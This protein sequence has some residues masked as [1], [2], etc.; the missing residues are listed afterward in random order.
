MSLYRIESPDRVW[1]A[2]IAAEWGAN[3]IRLQH[4]GQD[5]LIP[6]TSEQQQQENP[7]LIGSPLLFPANR[8]HKGQ[9]AFQGVT[10]RL[11]INEPF[12]DSHLHGLLHMQA[13]TMQ[14]I[15]D[16]AIVLTYENH[17]EIYPF[18]FRMTV[19]YRLQNEGLTQRYCVENIG[20]TDM[21]FT[22][23]LH[24]TFV[25]PPVF[26]VPI[27]ACQEKDER[28]IPTGRYVALNEQERMYPLG[29]PSKG[30]VLSGYYKACGHTAHVGEY[31]Y[32]VS[33]NF[34]H[35][36]LFNGRG[37]SGLLCVEPQCG[38]VNG[39]NN[40]DC[41]VLKPGESATFYTHLCRADT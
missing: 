37:E 16:S 11:P 30:L 13:F 35:W 9:F 8:T 6:L 28:H 5:V 1:C 15:T 38:A 23:A 21:P 20:T 22:F 19:E 29:S 3:V 41:K 18:P 2:E 36:I 4:D 27:C 12:T 34:D 39:L 25:E 7:Y 17:G 26:S 24:T 33:D 40:G 32:T 10:Y 14:T 31:T